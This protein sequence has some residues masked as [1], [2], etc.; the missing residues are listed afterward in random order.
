M[1]YAVERHIRTICMVIGMSVLVAGKEACVKQTEPQTWLVQAREAMLRDVMAIASK[2]PAQAGAPAPKKAKAAK[3][4]KG[5]AGAFRLM[6][7]MLV[8]TVPSFVTDACQQCGA[9]NGKAVGR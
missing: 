3:S 4:V 1:L 8:Q 6:A 9:I 2:A 5:A 7:R